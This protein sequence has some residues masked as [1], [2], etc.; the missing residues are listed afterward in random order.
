MIRFLRSPDLRVVS[1]ALLAALLL[2]L[3]R[4]VGTA[5]PLLFLCAVALFMAPGVMISRWFLREWS[6]GAAL[7]PVAFAISAGM[8]GI[9]GVP[10]LILNTSLDLYLILSGVIVAAFLIAGIARAAVGASAGVVKSDV[11]AEDSAGLLWAPFAVLTAALAFVSWTK[12]PNLY[13]DMWVYLSYVRAFLG[14]EP[15]AK[16]EPYFGQLTGIA[17]LKIN[18]WMLEQAALARVSGVDPV[19]MVIKYLNPALVVVGLLAFYSLARTLF[20]SALAAVLA[21]CLYAL[22]FLVQL[23]DSVLPP[24]SEFA[25]R[26]AEDKF[27][28]RFLFLPIALAAAVLF[29]RSRRGRYLAA[30]GLLCWAVVTVHPIG[31][32]MIGVAMAG[33]GLVYLAVN[34]R[35]RGAWTKVAALGAAGASIGL[36]PLA[37]VAATGERLADIL[38][39]SDISSGDPKVLANM[40]FVKPW[41]KKIL[42]FSDGSY[43]MHPAL[44]LDPTV[45]VALTA[46]LVFLLW[47]MRR[48]MTAQLLLGTLVFVAIVDYVP[49]IA[50]YVGDHFVLP[51]QLHRLAW[52]LS[53]AAMLT[54]CWMVWEAVRLAQARMDGRYTGRVA[55]LVPLLLVIVLMAVAAPWA[56]AGARDLAMGNRVQPGGVGL[57]FDP[58]FPWM[59]DNIREPS[60]VLAPDA[61]NTLIPAWSNKVNV[62]S[63]RGGL[64]FPV[65]ERLKERTNG[66]IKAPQGSI[67]VRTF[68]ATPEIAPKIEVLRR[69]KVDY[70]LVFDGSP[71]EKQLRSIPGIEPVKGAPTDR[72]SL[73]SV[74]LERLA[75]QDESLGATMISFSFS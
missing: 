14:D 37:L 47:R 5:A 23:S 61:E 12:I 42:E 49:Q 4:G 18:G 17:R 52:S 70:V 38:R 51:W 75:G 73:Y 71:L 19:E 25:V 59:R 48:S 27:A 57:G 22:Y 31:I 32:A 6:A 9:L 66:A 54:C 46:G 64:L 41:R 53:L 68:Y 7:V 26:L 36:L 74:D 58:I 40:V 29:L 8:F 2:V 65:L 50:T 45:L 55:R 3:L 39:A 62:V 44:L 16:Y 33:F 69:Y 56:V 13:D 21:S 67:D 24:G 43:I 28:A 35:E 72:Y 60:V 11:Q 10:M 20:R 15:L 34:W 63:L 30:F 1:L